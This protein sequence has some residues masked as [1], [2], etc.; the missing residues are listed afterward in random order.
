MTTEREQEIRAT[1][2]QRRFSMLN[3]V[4]LR[5]AQDLLKALDVE[6]AK[7]Q[8]KCTL[9]DYERHAIT[10]CREVGAVGFAGRS[11]L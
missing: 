7:N 3:T 4:P 8:R 11:N 10:G 5:M 2:E 9:L 6:R 1:I